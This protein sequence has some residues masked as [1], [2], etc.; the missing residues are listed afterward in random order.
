MFAGFVLNDFYFGS[1]GDTIMFAPDGSWF[2]AVSPGMLCATSS[3]D[4]ST[5]AHGKYSI[6]PVSEVP[7]PAA[8]WLF[9]SALGGLG[10]IGRRR[11]AA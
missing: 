1:D 11:K 7:L 5:G 2:C 9:L 10:L 3:T 4:L 6:A 8:I